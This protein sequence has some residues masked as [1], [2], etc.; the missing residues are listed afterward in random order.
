MKLETEYQSSP[1]QASI[2]FEIFDKGFEY[3]KVFFFL[4]NFFTYIQ[5]QKLEDLKIL[6]RSLHLFNNV[7]IGQGQLRLIIKHILFSHIWGLQPF[8]SN[9]NSIKQ[10][11]DF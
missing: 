6:R 7:K 4:P 2:N 1:L 8:W 5:N 3:S 10:P 11:S 9:E